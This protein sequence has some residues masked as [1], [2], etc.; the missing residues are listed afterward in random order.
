MTARTS[1]RKLAQVLP[2][3]VV[4]DVS[5]T[6][7]PFLS[8]ALLLSVSLASAIAFR[9][10]SHAY[11]KL[12]L[13]SRFLSLLSSHSRAFLPVFPLY[14]IAIPRILSLR[15]QIYRCTF[16]AQTGIYRCSFKK[17]TGVSLKNMMAH[18]AFPTERNLLSSAQFLQ[19][20]LPVRLAHRV[21]ELENLPYGLS[22]KAPVLKLEKLPYGLSTKA[23]VLK[24]R[25]CSKCARVQGAPVLKVSCFP[26]FS[27]QVR[28][29][30]VNSFKGILVFLLSLT[31]SCPAPPL[32]SRILLIPVHVCV[33]VRDWYV[34]SFKDIR[35]F[36]AIESREEELRFTHLLAQVKMRHNNVI[37][38][39]WTGQHELHLAQV[40]MR[41]NNVIPTV[42]ER[43]LGWLWTGQHELHLAQV[44]MRHN[45]VIL[46]MAMGINELKQDLGRKGRL[47]DLLEIH[48]FLVRPPLSSL[49]PS[50]PALPATPAVTAYPPLPHCSHCPPIVTNARTAFMTLTLLTRLPSLPP[51]P[52]LP[53]FS[54]S[55]C[56]PCLLP[57]LSSPHTP[58][59]PHSPHSPPLTLLSPTCIAQP[60]TASTCHASACSLASTGKAAW[61]RLS[62]LHVHLSVS[63]APLPAHS[64]LPTS[65]A[66]AHHDRFYMSRI[67]IRMLIGQHVWAKT[68]SAAASAVI[69]S[70]SLPHTPPPAAPPCHPAH[71]DRF[72][73]SRIGIRML[74]GQ[75]VALHDPN[76]PPHFIG[77][78]SLPPLHCGSL[79]LSSTACTG[80][81]ALD[82]MHWTACT[83]P[84]ALDR[85]HWTACTGPHA[86]DRMHWTACTS[87]PSGCSPAC[88]KCL[89]PSHLSHY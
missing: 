72:Y 6:P 43:V 19:Q 50:L 30:Y 89:L 45:N 62:L 14:I 20:E 56:P 18:G 77:C 34:D 23:P 2:S 71:Q 16:K 79:S 82:R 15:R 17:Q 1:A 31:P 13:L 83:G 67:G 33:Q 36:P 75:H 73:M 4:A 8:P 7:L 3:N 85:M 52:S 46:T 24:V 61:A 78:A 68:L 27:A 49:P 12:H 25:P 29:W 81:H 76:P 59:T 35:G 80:P 51:L 66:H 74:I 37:P 55:Q 64:P 65:P 53:S 86:L 54:A 88:S 40:K 28:D 69:C 70:L 42:R 44:K 48:Q 60:L 32:S 9:M 87:N 21:T 26:L 84:H 57:S 39:L 63:C 47:D 22:T 10:L 41:H 38:T 5:R 58:H 11:S